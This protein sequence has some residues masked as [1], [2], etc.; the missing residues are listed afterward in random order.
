MNITAKEL[1][2]LIK[3]EIVGNPDIKVSSVSEIENGKHGDICFLSN[4][5]YE[6][7]IYKCA[8]SIIITSK[9]FSPREKINKTI[10]KVDDPYLAFS[11]IMD[12]KQDILPDQIGISNKSEI[13]NTAK[14]NKEVFIGNFTTI[15]QNVSVEKNVK[16]HSNCFIGENVS[17]GKNTIIFSGVKIYHNCQIGENNIIHS[18][19]VIGADGFGFAQN[20]EKYKKIKQ[21]GNVITSKNVEIGANT[22]IDRATMGST[23]IGEGVKL[24][25][26]IQIAHNVKIGKHAVIAAQVGIAGSTVI[27]DYVDIGD[28]T[29]IAGLTAIAGSTKIGKEC[30]IGGHTA[31]AGHLKIGNNVKI[32]GHSGVGSNIKD[33]QAIQG[34]FAFEIKKFQRSYVLFKRLPEIYNKLLKITKRT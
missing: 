30:M 29:V 3:G 23:K 22:T 31:I 21:I 28:N 2:K 1:A 26:L 17:I 15:A 34:P 4:K 16:I 19:A 18:G 25:N 20:K 32:A 8:A 24:D 14:I 10:I 13:S 9:K 12:L 7:Y 6:P 33:N 5:K 11:Q 27:G